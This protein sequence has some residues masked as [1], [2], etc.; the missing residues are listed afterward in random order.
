MD[1]LVRGGALWA[2]PGCESHWLRP[3]DG[4]AVRIRLD[5]VVRP[6]RAT[7]SGGHPWVLSLPGR[8][9]SLGRVYEDALGLAPGT[10]RGLFP[11]DGLAPS[12]DDVVD[13]VLA[14]A[15]HRPDPVA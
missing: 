14:A 13:I 4:C 11:R 12:W 6:T 10:L 1:A 3:L 9:R 7:W 2:I 8:R 15:G 5:G